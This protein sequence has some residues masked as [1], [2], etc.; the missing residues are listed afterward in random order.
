MKIAM[1]NPEVEVEIERLI[2]RIWAVPNFTA[3]DVD[4]AIRAAVKWA[5]AD[6]ATVCR[7]QNQLFMSPAVEACALAIESR[8]NLAQTELETVQVRRKIQTLRTG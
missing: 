3:V 5:Y 1:I 2:Q 6:A 8:T 4:N 7:A